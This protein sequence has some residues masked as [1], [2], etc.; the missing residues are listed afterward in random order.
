LPGWSHTRIGCC[1]PRPKNVAIGG[2][3]D[4]A[5]QY[6]RA[7]LID[8]VQI[9]LVPVLLGAGI[10]LFDHLGTEQIRLERTRAIESP[11][12]THLRFRVIK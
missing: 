1:R 8:E 11:F 2:G 7:G 10:R 4:I 12:A 6:L 9:H 5:Q 3:A